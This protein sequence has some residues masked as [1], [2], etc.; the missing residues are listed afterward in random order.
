MRKVILKCLL[1]LVIGGMVYL[2]FFTVPIEGM[3]FSEKITLLIAFIAMMATW[4]SA[5][6][7]KKSSEIAQE[8]FESNM[9]ASVHNNFEQRYNSLLDLHNDLHKSVGIFLDA[10]DKMDGKGGIVA[11]G[12]KSYFQNIRKMKTLEE[13]HNTLMGHSIISPYMRVLYHLLKHIFTYSTNPDI[14]KNYTSPLR[15]LIRNDVLYLVA[16]NTAIIYKDDSLDDNGY[17]EF[18][19]YLQKSDFFEHTIFTADEYKNFNEVRSDVKFSFDRNFNVPIS[20]YILNYVKTLRFQNDV[21]DLHKDLMLCV[22]FKNPFT[23]LVNSYVN[24][25]LLVVK[26]SYKYHLDEILKSESRYLGLLND[27]CA[28]YEKENKEREFTLINNFSTL[29]EVANSNKDKYTLFFVRRSN[30]LPNNCLNVV[31]WIVELDRSREVLRQHENN[32]L[33]VE[34]DLDNISKSFLSIFNKSVNK[35]KLNNLF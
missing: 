31:N 19:K 8:T 35:Y 28:Y 2:L 20:N 33:K 26:E 24:N 32:K 23:P 17:Q 5:R 9:R 15:S 12:G 34:K 21:I 25:I 27:L 10:P 16:L 30:G 7:S 3:K 6:S 29:R 11:P 18:Q 4:D 1:G 13:A 14:Y 22:I